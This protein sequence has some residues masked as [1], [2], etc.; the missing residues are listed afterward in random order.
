MRNSFITDRQEI[1]YAIA[2]VTRLKQEIQKTGSLPQGW[3]R[4][5]VAEV[6]DAVAWSP[7]RDPE[8]EHRLQDEEGRWGDCAVDQRHEPP[9]PL[10][11]GMRSH[12]CVRGGASQ[13]LL[14]SADIWKSPLGT[15]RSPASPVGWPG[16]FGFLGFFFLHKPL[17]SG[18]NLQ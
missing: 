5:G 11:P 6:E 12:T 7:V 4:L 1:G 15:P 2:Y 18:Y 3:R 17:I 8:G 9:P 13:E 10:P 16:W 14:S